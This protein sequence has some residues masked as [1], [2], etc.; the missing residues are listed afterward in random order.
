MAQFY[1]ERS[2]R[3]IFSTACLADIYLD[4]SSVLG[5]ASC[6][7]RAR[8]SAYPLLQGLVGFVSQLRHRLSMVFVRRGRHVNHDFLVSLSGDLHGVFYS[9]IGFLQRV[10]GCC[11]EVTPAV[12]N[13][14]LQNK[15]VTWGVGTLSFRGQVFCTFPFRRQVLL[16]AFLQRWES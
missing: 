6:W 2:L 10:G 3:F 13:V 15:G 14:L 7:W 12:L 11:P 1:I 16:V 4:M 5:I 8:A 9:N